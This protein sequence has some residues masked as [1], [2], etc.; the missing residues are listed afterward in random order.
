MILKSSRSDGAWKLWEN[1]EVLSETFPTIW[2]QP[3]VDLNPLSPPLP[4]SPHLKAG[5]TLELPTPF[6]PKNSNLLISPDTAPTLPKELPSPIRRT[7]FGAIYRL[8][9]ADNLK[10][11]EVKEIDREDK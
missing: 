10:P 9:S 3:K 5:S 1:K 4:P 7:R 11:N 2:F 6:V 8:G